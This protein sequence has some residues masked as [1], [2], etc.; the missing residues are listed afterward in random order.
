MN[1]VHSGC[2]TAPV[3][4]RNPCGTRGWSPQRADIFFCRAPRSHACHVISVRQER[5]SGSRRFIRSA[6]RSA[7]KRPRSTRFCCLCLSIT[8]PCI[9]RSAQILVCHLT[10][11]HAATIPPIPIPNCSSAP[12]TVPAPRLARGWSVGRTGRA[13]RGRP[14]RYERRCWPLH[15]P[16]SARP[17]SSNRGARVVRCR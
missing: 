10:W 15:P 14:N 5:T 7:E 4:P 2:K 16:P 13:A 3:T 11:P 6:F 1:L 12:S 17:L 9:R 8:S